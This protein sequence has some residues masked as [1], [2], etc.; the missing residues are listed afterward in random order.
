MPWQFEQQTGQITDQKGFRWGRS[1]AGRGEGKNNPVLQDVRAGCRYD[2]EKKLWLPVDG[3]TE[4]DWGPLPCGLYTMCEPEDTETHGP[5]VIWLTPF[6]STQMF[7][8]S[9]MGWHGDS[10]KDPGVASEGCICSPRTV[11]QAGWG[12]SDHQLQVVPG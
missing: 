8:R 2:N 1:Y 6:P 9:G 4:N 7:G 3:L 11:R 12:S 5:Y 10:N